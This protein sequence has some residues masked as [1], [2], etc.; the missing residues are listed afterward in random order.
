MGVAEV[1]WRLETGWD[2]SV[3]GLDLLEPTTLE[4]SSSTSE[5]WLASLRSYSSRGITDP[6]P[7]LWLALE[8]LESLLWIWS[9]MAPKGV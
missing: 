4:E 8:K 7:W 5:S 9:W 1:F 2:D 3:G 6:E